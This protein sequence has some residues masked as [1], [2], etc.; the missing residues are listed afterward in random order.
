MMLKRGL[1]DAWAWLKALTNGL[2]PQ[3]H[4][5]NRLTILMFHR[6]LPE[7]YRKQYAY[8]GLVTTPEELDWLL[9]LLTPHFSIR[10]VSRSMVSFHA[11]PDTKPLLALTFDDGQWDNFNYA[12][13][14][15]ERHGVKAT[16]YIP[17]DPID[18]HRLIWHDLL[19]FGTQYFMRTHSHKQEQWVAQLPDHCH[20]YAFSAAELV[21]E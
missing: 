7:Q 18:H 2:S 20:P 19:A 10:T 9:T 6:C 3:D 16:F 21:Q 15:L 13:P 14:V 8:P 11:E 4:N 17:T 12:H 1:I 5:G